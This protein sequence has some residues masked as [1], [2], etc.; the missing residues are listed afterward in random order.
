MGLVKRFE[1]ASA[2]KRFE[3]Q[4]TTHKSQDATCNIQRAICCGMNGLSVLTFRLENVIQVITSMDHFEAGP[5]VMYA[6]VFG[7]IDPA[8]L[9]FDFVTA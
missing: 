4:L 6:P 8:L 3:E 1:R 7:G 2:I 5:G 9:P